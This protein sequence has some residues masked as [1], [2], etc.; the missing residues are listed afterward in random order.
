GGTV[1]EEGAGDLRGV[2]AFFQEN[3]V[4]GYISIDGPNMNVIT[5]LGTGS[6][7]YQITYKGSG[8]HSFADFGSPSAT[9]GLGR[10]IAAIAQ[11]ETK[12]NP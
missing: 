11:L 9:H 3:M 2:K 7:R 1:G 12:A 10:A 8:G 5:Y 6:Y 4:D